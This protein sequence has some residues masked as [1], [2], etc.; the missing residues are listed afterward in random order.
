ERFGGLLGR[1]GFTV[2]SGGAR[3]IDTA[4]HR[5]AF[6]SGGRTIIVQGTGLANPYPR[7][8]V[9]FFDTILA[10]GSG[11]MISELPM[12][13]TPGPGNFPARNR[14]IS[15]MSLGVI[16]VEAGLPSGAL[17]TAR[18]ALEQN[19]EVFAVPGRVDSPQSTGTHQLL[20][21]GAT[22]A[23]DLDDILKNLGQV[24]AELD[25]REPLPSPVKPQ[26]LT[27]TQ[28]ALYSLLAEKAMTLDELCRATSGQPGQIAGDLTLLALRGAITQQPGNVFTLK[29]R[30]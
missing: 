26:N 27:P 9:P 15:G 25:R 21:D 28:D 29:N 13:T 20:R 8:N 18:E 23:A 5:G 1:A 30:H 17:I 19:R 4:A 11:A 6:Y 2:I 22:L 7:E 24:G 10:G 3:G 12:R 14:I 16:V